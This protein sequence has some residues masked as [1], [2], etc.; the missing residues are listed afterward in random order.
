MPKYSGTPLVIVV[1]H[2]HSRFL[3]GKRIGGPYHG[4]WQFPGGKV[5]SNET[6][7]AAAV[8]ELFEE[9]GLVVQ[10]ADLRALAEFDWDDRTRCWVFLYQVPD[11]TVVTNREPAKCEG[12][13]W[14]QP[15]TVGHEPHMPRTDRYLAAALY[16]HNRVGRIQT[17]QCHIAPVLGG[18]VVSFYYGLPKAPGPYWCIHPRP[19]GTLNDPHLALIESQDGDLVDIS[20]DEFGPRNV[21][22]AY[23]SAPLITRR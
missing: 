6:P 10:P 23:Y 14:V 21:T 13:W 1:P 11:R 7:R 3:A 8:R 22:D 9:T 5:E 20:S 18:E 17:G 12:W 4:L 19:N 2:N 15:E 16:Q